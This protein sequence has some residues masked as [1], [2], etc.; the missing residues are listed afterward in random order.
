MTDDVTRSGTTL[1]TA[2]EDKIDELKSW[3]LS[4]ES[5]VRADKTS[6]TYDNEQL[7]QEA[8]QEIK[9]CDAQIERVRTELS[10]LKRREAIE[11]DL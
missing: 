8:A 11:A 4:R 10:A 2:I 5:W 1:R 9:N 3:R 7:Q 6:R